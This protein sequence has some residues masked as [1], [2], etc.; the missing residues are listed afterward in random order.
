MTTDP[1][2]YL[3]G[4]FSCLP[5]EQRTRRHFLLSHVPKNLLHAV[6]WSLQYRMGWV[7]EYGPKLDQMTDLPHSQLF[8]MSADD[9]MVKR[10]L[11][12]EFVQLQ[13]QRGKSVEMR[14]WPHGHHCLYFREPDKSEEY[15]RLCD[16]FYRRIFAD[17]LV[18]AKL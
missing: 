14:C 9:K 11:V 2:F 8:L 1:F 7:D 12:Q 18:Q 17:S 13:L 15:R 3:A 4:T 5:R 16:R 6:W 10:E